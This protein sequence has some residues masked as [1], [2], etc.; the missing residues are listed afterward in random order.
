MDKNN[1]QKLQNFMVIDKKVKEE[2]IKICPPSESEAYNEASIIK[3]ADYT[4]NI[5]KYIFAELKTIAIDFNSELFLN[6]IKEMEEKIL[7]EFMSCSQDLNKLRVFYRD[8]ITDMSKDLVDSVKKECVGYKLDNTPIESIRKTKTMNELLHVIHCYIMNNEYIYQSTNKI[9]EKLNQEN[10]SISLYGANNEFAYKLF[11][12]F[13][14]E[15]SCGCTDIV[16]LGN[17]KVMMMI[18][19]RGHAL[20][21]ETEK[22]EEGIRVS[23]FIPK[24]C[25]IEMINNLPGIHKAGENAEI[26][27]G[28]TGAFVADEEEIYLKIYQFISMVPMDSNMTFENNNRVM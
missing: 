24:L 21:I 16:S 19:D 7:D 20:T 9:A 3:Y 15:L 8:T 6:K 5:L 27:S 22:T 2:I 23:Y 4:Y 17:Q 28:A 14:I 26:Y 13:P 11:E 25:N 18:R 1:L 10:Y 12:L